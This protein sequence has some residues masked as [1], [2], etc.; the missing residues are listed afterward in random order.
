MFRFIKST[1]FVSLSQC[2]L[3]T[4]VPP[5]DFGDWRPMPIKAGLFKTVWVFRSLSLS[6]VKLVLED[7][8]KRSFMLFVGCFFA[9]GEYTL[10][11]SN[12]IQS[13]IIVFVAIAIAI[14]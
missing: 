3:E 11:Y 13:N 10:I 2:L 7:S 6:P 5:L 8:P 9:I 14:Y 1:D 12:L 4:E